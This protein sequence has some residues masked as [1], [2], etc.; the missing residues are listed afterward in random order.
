[1]AE[2]RTLTDPFCK[3]VGPEAVRKLHWDAKQ[4]HLALSVEPSGAKAWK[5][6]YRFDGKLRWLALGAYPAIG[7]GAA[8]EA[9]SVALAKVTL[10][11]DPQAEKIAAREAAKR[12]AKAETLQSVHRRY[13]EEHAKRENKSWRQGESVMKAYVLPT[14]GARKIADIER[15]DVRRIFDEITARA[16]LAANLMLNCASGVFSWALE[17]DLVPANPC[18]GISR[19]ATKARDRW[20]NADELRAVVPALEKMDT[21]EARGL[22]LVL[23]TGCRPGE[24]SAMRWEHVAGSWWEQPGEPDPAIGWPGTKNGLTHRVYLSDAAQ[25]I[26][27]RSGRQARGFVFIGARARHVAKLDGVTRELAGELGIKAFTPHALRATVASHLSTMKVPKDTIS[28]VLNHIEGGVTAGYIRHSYDA[29][30]QAAL[31]RWG[32]RVREIVAGDVGRVIALR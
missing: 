25:A 28:K 4:P 21:A 22:L 20:L 32:E 14:L 11:R 16:P 3:S 17:H 5:V 1:M 9:A 6:A 29:E 2:K 23:L 15:G 19:N 7:L 8:R 13:L 26:L 30:K 10:G 31:V 18:A 27:D 24:A 12:E